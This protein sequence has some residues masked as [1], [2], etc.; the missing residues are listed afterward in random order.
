[1]TELGFPRVPYVELYLGGDW[2]NVVDDVRQ[3]PGIVIERGRKNE[4]AK[5]TPSSCTF[6]LDNSTDHGDG[7]YTPR[8]PLG[9]WYPSFGRNVPVRVGLEAGVDDFDRTVASGWGTGALGAWSVFTAGGT[10]ATSVASGT[11]R[12]S[13]TSTNASAMTYLDDLSVR[14]VEVQ[15]D[16]TISDAD[17]SGAAVSAGIV[18]RG[19]DT[20]NFMSVALVVNTDETVQLWLLSDPSTFATGA[21]NLSP[22][23]THSGQQWTIKAQVEGRTLRGKAWPSTFVEP[24]DWQGSAVIDE[25]YGAGWVGARSTVFSGNTDLKPLVFS[26]DDFRIRLPRF[27]GETAE[28][29]PGMNLAKTDKWVDVECGTLFRRLEQGESPVVSPMQRYIAD[30]ADDIG[31]FGYWPVEDGQFATELA[32][33]LPTHDPMRILRGGVN[34]KFSED[35]T[36][37]ASAPLPL[38]GTTEFRVVAPRHT[39]TGNYQWRSLLKIG[40][41]QDAT[42]IF[43]YEFM[44]TGQAWRWHVQLEQDGS[45]SVRAWDGNGLILDDT[46]NGVLTDI[47]MYM[48]FALS[49]D[50]PDIDYDISYLRLDDP[51]NTV[52]FYEAGGTVVGKTLGT[53]TRFGVI[54]GVPDLGFPGPR[55]T[56]VGH[57]S[58][59]AGSSSLPA[60]VLADEYFRSFPGESVTRR[61]ARL[62]TEAG[63]PAAAES[64]ADSISAA[65][66]PQQTDT[67]VN[68]LNEGADTDLGFLHEARGANVFAYKPIEALYVPV[69][70]VTLDHDAGHLAPTFEPT[71]DDQTVRNDVT[72][73]ARRGSEARSTVTTG[74]NNVNDPGTTPGA[75]G[76]Y[77]ATVQTN[78]ETQPQ[79]ASV[80]GWLTHLGT[81]DEPRFPRIN[82]DL[83]ADVFRADPDLTASVLDLDIGDALS[84]ENLEDWH[85]FGTVQ[86]LVVGYTEVF[87][88]AYQHTIAFNTVPAS[89]YRVGQLDDGALRLD[90][91]STLDE[92]L[93]TTETA[94]TVA[95]P[96]LFG[97][98]WTTDPAEYPFDLAVG[99]E[100]MTATACIGTGPQTFTV[101]RSVNGV[102][103]THSSGD[104]ISLADPYYLGP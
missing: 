90:L 71:D 7:D 99:G 20:A 34:T 60:I 93:D 103:K 1:M 89:P 17:I 80:A 95:T 50:G 48:Q 51:P 8:N 46:G 29:T 44:F 79:L 45:L 42:A 4:A 58:V 49:Q 9:Q 100:R 68:L 57:L 77:D 22:I 98:L 82:I 53:M 11:G 73:K 88:T 40:G 74:P 54:G 23:F 47:P 2:H 85:I 87:D 64:D 3:D 59:G 72:A 70:L 37:P 61:N 25:P 6:T 14:D 75:V 62:L 19:Q 15:V 76:R 18:L 55:D 91:D 24:L 84:V 86:Q 35:D 97:T 43:V 69:S 16:V 32:P 10:V 21:V 94:V 83:G 81:V 41:G 92:D 30:N 56:V 39:R 12:H 27:A 65:M 102:V 5:P 67:L 26:Y 96:D 104:A 52:H 101:T 28:L 31:I 66:G 36:F 78:P 13:I 38:F 33:G 63:L